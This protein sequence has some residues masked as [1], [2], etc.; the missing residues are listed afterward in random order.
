MSTT[1]TVATKDERDLIRAIVRA[2]KRDATIT[3]LG[4]GRI[5]IGGWHA[6]TVHTSTKGV[7][8]TRAGHSK[9]YPHVLPKKELLPYIKEI[10]TQMLAAE[11]AASINADQNPR[12]SSD[13]MMRVLF[14]AKTTARNRAM[15]NGKGTYTG[16]VLRVFRSGDVAQ[17]IG[18]SAPDVERALLFLVNDGY[19]RDINGTG[20]SDRWAGYSWAL[21]DK[22]A[23]SESPEPRVD[24]QPAGGESPQA[25]VAQ[26][27]AQCSARH[28]RHWYDVARD[29]MTWIAMLQLLYRAQIARQRSQTAYQDGVDAYQWFLHSDDADDDPAPTVPDLSGLCPICGNTDGDWVQCGD[30]GAFVPCPECMKWEAVTEAEMVPFEGRTAFTV[31]H[32]AL[33]WHWRGES[34]NTWRRVPD[35]YWLMS[36]WYLDDYPPPMP[37][38]YKSA[39]TLR[40]PM[41]TSYRQAYYA[42][43]GR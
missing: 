26:E 29:R 15:T 10:K 4:N 6:T 32:G 23:A 39:I 37:E 42:R 27:P 35:G 31:K 24:V 16:K 30:G 9:T 5:Q 38:G 3:D 13:V 8:L 17:L 7:V 19:V 36:S 41:Q 25:P 14:A 33:W 22:G 18:M 43:V 1:T 34:L 2:L 12:P 11:S 40:N 21:T 28:V 20:K